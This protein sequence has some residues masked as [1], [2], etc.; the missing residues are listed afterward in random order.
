[1]LFR[2]QHFR[3]AHFQKS[4]FEG[5]E[6]TRDGRFEQVLDV[7]IDVLLSVSEGDGDVAASGLQLGRFLLAEDVLADVEIGRA[8]CRERV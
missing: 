2:S 3:S 4:V 8:S 5:S 1:M 6:L 7:E